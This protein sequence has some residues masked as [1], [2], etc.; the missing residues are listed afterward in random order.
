M[1]AAGIAVAASIAATA[2]AQT[3]PT[4]PIRLMV[5]T[6]AGGSP[7]MVARLVGQHLTQ[8]LGQQVVVD[9]RPGASG[10]VGVQGPWRAARRTVTPS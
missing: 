3:Y 10:V 4:K 8:S 2:S 1:A 6:T 5:N 9:N 7:D